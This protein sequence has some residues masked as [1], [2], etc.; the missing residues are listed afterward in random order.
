MKR[1]ISVPAQPVQFQHGRLPGRHK[2][3]SAGL[4]AYSHDQ[5]WFGINASH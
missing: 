4:Q 3:A 2:K 5:S 1:L